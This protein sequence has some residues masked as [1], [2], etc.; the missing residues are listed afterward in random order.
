MRA[1]LFHACAM[2]MPATYSGF[3]GNA[4]IATGTL[5]EVGLALKRAVGA[6]GR[7]LIFDNATGKVVDLHLNGSDDDLRQRA[8]AQSPAADDAE[9]PAPEARGRGRPK[10]GVVAREVTLLPRHWEW[11]AGEPG[12]ASIALRKLVETARRSPEGLQR[13]RRERAYQFM[14]TM[15]NHEPGFEDATRALFAD[16]QERLRELGAT[17]PPD[18][19]AHVLKLAFDEG[20]LT[21]PK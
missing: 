3:N 5:A 6:D 1:S 2:S 19:R 16:E 7:P 14:F 13:R 20:G 15:L 12:G 21:S 8:Q 17:W 9:A 18:V 11:L 4:H 10:L